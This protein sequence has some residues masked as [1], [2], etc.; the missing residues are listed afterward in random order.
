[1]GLHEHDVIVKLNGVGV[2][3]QEQ[4]RKM[5]R[6][7]PAG[8]TIVLVVSRQGQSLTL[9]AQMADLSQIEREAWEQHLTAPA[10]LAASG[11]SASL[12]NTMA[13][14]P[15]IDPAST[16]Q[17]VP[18]TAARANKSFLGTLLTSPTYTGAVLETMSPQLGQFFGVNGR[19]GLLVR[20]VAGNSPAEMAGLKA[21]DVVTKV[22][23]RAMVSVSTWTKVIK[24][25][26][27]RPVTVTVV[28]DRLEKTLTV[29][30]DVK[31]K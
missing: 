19:G 14:A 2:M 15:G 17:P 27:G 8:K 13:A 28:R 21:G 7:I 4:M 24:E 22:N 11:P 10:V 5:M 29:V 26:K 20:S 30:P 31:H 1:M 9:S 6:E 25:A 3:G 12:A 16:A 18:L 23:F